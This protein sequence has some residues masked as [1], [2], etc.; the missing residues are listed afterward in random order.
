MGRAKTLTVIVSR[1]AVIRKDGLPYHSGKR[2]ELLAAHALE[3]L[4]SGAV[5]TPPVADPEAFDPWL[6]YLPDVENALRE[7]RARKPRPR[8]AKTIEEPA[9]RRD[10]EPLP[11]VAEPVQAPPSVRQPL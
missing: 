9:R 3:L 6:D 1:G 11:E 4:R 2:V 10:V 7:A 8:K 5:K